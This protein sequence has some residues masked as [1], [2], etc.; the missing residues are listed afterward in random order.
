VSPPSA[1]LPLSPATRAARE[2]ATMREALQPYLGQRITVTAPVQRM[3]TRIG[4]TGVKLPTLLV[5]PVLNADGTELADHL[6]L[7]VGRRLAAVA[8][9]PGDT[10]T[11]TG[12]VK[13]YTRRRRQYHGT[14]LTFESDLGLAYPARCAVVARAEIAE[15]VRMCVQTAPEPVAV[16]VERVIQDVATPVDVPARARVLFALAVLS[17]EETE[18]VSLTKL[19]ARAG[20]PPLALLSQLKKLGNAGHISFTPAGRVLLTNQPTAT[21]LEVSA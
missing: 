2:A 1:A 6:W 19:N 14:T 4:W 3:G 11:L 5:G 12:R 18:G 13:P 10:L 15:D 8:P 17:L 21:S 7:H 16:N 9:Q 20:V